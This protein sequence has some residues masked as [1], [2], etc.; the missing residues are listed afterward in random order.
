MA[1]KRTKLQRSP[2]PVKWLELKAN[3][4]LLTMKEAASRLGISAR[5]AASWRARNLFRLV[6]LPACRPGARRSIRVVASG[7]MPMVAL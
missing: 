4:S 3:E 5:L 7:G 6:L 2:A 1:T